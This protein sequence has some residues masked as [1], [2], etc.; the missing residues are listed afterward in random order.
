MTG[1]EDKAAHQQYY[2][3]NKIKMDVIISWCTVQ[4][5]EMRS[6]ETDNVASQ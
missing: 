3:N 2:E 6:P 4:G 1:S 5:E